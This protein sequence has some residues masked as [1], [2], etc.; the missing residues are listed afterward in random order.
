[1]AD[2]R[3]MPPFTARD[4]VDLVDEEDSRLLDSLHGF[5]S[6]L[7]GVHELVLL[8]ADEELARLRYLE[9]PGP[10]PPS[11]EARHHVLEV[12][13]HLLEAL[14]SEDLERGRGP[15]LDLDL[16]DAVLE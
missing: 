7:I 8:L 10:P 15:R 9:P 6:D 11:E 14:R 5:R 1:A 3:P 2:L 13:P 4:L 12:H 16:D